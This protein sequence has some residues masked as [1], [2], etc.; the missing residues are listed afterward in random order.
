MEQEGPEPIATT[1]PDFS[2]MS[3][4]I[5]TDQGQ[6]EQEE[7]EEEETKYSISRRLRTYGFMAESEGGAAAERAV[8]EF[9]VVG[10]VRAADSGA[11]Y[12][13]L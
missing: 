10:Y 2:L 6:E 7:E 5:C 3:A 4:Y 8:G 12:E 11:F 9:V 1:I 13:D